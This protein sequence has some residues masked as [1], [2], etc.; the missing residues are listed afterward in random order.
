MSGR[1]FL[2]M[3]PV[4]AELLDSASE[5]RGSHKTSEPS[6]RANTELNLS[7]L[8]PHSQLYISGAV[9]ERLMEGRASEPLRGS[10]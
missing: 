7:C 9:V 3:A 5:I 1:H 6:V 2:R 8:D 10:S 4:G